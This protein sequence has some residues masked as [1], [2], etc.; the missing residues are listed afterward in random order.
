MTQVVSK[1]VL[2]AKMLEILRHLEQNQEELIITDNNI[3]VLKIVPIKKK[4]PPRDIFPKV[5]VRYLEPLET[6]AS[7]EDWEALK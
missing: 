2:K 7:Q 4:T 3:P 6:P 1:S 5:R